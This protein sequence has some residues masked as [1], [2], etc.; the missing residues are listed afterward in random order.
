MR[1]DELEELFLFHAQEIEEQVQR[2]GAPAVIFVDQIDRFLASLATISNIDRHEVRGTPKPSLEIFYVVAHTLHETFDLLIIIF[3]RNA[4]NLVALPGELTLDD[5][6][7]LFYVPRNEGAEKYRNRVPQFLHWRI[8]VRS[9]VAL[10][11]LIFRNRI[12]QHAQHVL[13]VDAEINLDVEMAF[14]RKLL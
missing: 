14:V 13:G 5:L 1:L 2:S 6:N 10:T 12:V 9:Q 4:F 7:L 3:G 8:G 11:N